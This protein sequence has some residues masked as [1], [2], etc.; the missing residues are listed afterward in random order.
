MKRKMKP[1]HNPQQKPNQKPNQN[2]PLHHQQNPNP[3][4]N[5]NLLKQIQTYS[6]IQ[7]Y[8]KK[9][10]AT[11]IAVNPKPPQHGTTMDRNDDRKHWANKG[12][13]YI[14]DQLDMRGIRIPTYKFRGKGALTKRD[15]LKIL[16]KHDNI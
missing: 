15:L 4:H 2:Q 5:L 1:P 6:L 9:S 13:G 3:N 7:K 11:G 12:L 14:K 10:K 8:A 16:Y